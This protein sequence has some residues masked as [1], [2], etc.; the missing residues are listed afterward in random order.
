MSR[1]LLFLYITIF[2]VAFTGV[3]FAVAPPLALTPMGFTVFYLPMLALTLFLHWLM[4]RRQRLVV[5]ICGGLMGAI[6]AGMGVLLAAFFAGF[7]T[8]VVHLVHKR[9]NRPRVSTVIADKPGTFYQYAGTGAT[10]SYSPVET[11]A[12]LTP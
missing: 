5:I 10:M 8:G 1:K 7:L 6:F 4:P 2:L 12:R 3:L 9:T 11:A